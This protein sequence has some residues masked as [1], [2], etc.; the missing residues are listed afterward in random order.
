MSV[1]EFSEG[2]NTFCE[3]SVDVSIINSERSFEESKIEVWKE[4]SKRIQILDSKDSQVQQTLVDNVLIVKEP[5]RQLKERKSAYWKKRVVIWGCLS[6]FSATLAAGFSLGI[7]SAATSSYYVALPAIF[8]CGAAGFAIFSG[9]QIG[10]WGNNY[11]ETFANSRREAFVR[12]FDFVVKNKQRFL[13]VLNEQEKKG[14]YFEFFKSLVIQSQSLYTDKDRYNF[15]EK[16]MHNSPL[17]KEAQSY[18]QLSA[19]QE[20]LLKPSCERYLELLYLFNNFK[21]D[22]ES[23]KEVFSFQINSKLYKIEEKKQKELDKFPILEKKDLSF[24]D[25]PSDEQNRLLFD[26]AQDETQPVPFVLE[27]EEKRDSLYPECAPM[28]LPV[29]EPPMGLPVEEFPTSMQIKERNQVRKEIIAFFDRKI[30]E[31]IRLKRNYNHY[32]ENI[33]QQQATR[34]YYNDF[35]AIHENGYM[36]LTKQK[37]EPLPSLSSLTSQNVQSSDILKLSL[38]GV[39]YQFEID[40]IFEEALK[41]E[42][43]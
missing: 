26:H 36:A 42:F 1:R 43:S 13:N 2:S 15:F 25:C 19:F 5:S 23:I 40:T 21:R 6:L 11:A 16:T 17:L 3:E 34:L 33:F 28:G 18:S 22:K 32:L 41:A 7:I 37:G 24:S 38:L 4:L 8:S 10:K 9:A 20:S 31:M 12:G 35:V 14:L 29:E 27:S 39:S 30:N